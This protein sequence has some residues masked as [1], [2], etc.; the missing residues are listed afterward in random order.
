[1]VLDRMDFIAVYEAAEE[2]L[3]LAQVALSVF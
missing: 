3:A 2:A 1:M